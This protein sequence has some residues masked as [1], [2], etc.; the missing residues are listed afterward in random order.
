MYNGKCY[1]WYD[2]TTNLFDYTKTQTACTNP[3]AATCADNS[4]ACITSGV[5]RAA[6]FDTWTDFNAITTAFASTVTN[7]IQI[8]VGCTTGGG[9]NYDPNNVCAASTI[10]VPSTDW[11]STAFASAS[12]ESTSLCNSG[13]PY[14]RITG[15]W[16]DWEPYA[17]SGGFNGYMC[18][19]GM[20]ICY[21]N[22]IAIIKE[23]IQSQFIKH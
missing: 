17:S 8:G 7:P 11:P 4:G 21:Y 12:M 14:V 10:V 23:Q 3:I 1:L 18:E 9:I 13:N 19:A 5:G 16:N 2:G 15:Q 6:T 22:S 20:K